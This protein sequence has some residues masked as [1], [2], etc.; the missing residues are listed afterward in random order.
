[1][2]LFSLLVVQVS[3]TALGQDPERSGQPRTLDPTALSFPPHPDPGQRP[4]VSIPTP[5]SRI[6]SAKTQIHT[7]LRAGF[8]Y[9]QS[10]HPH[11]KH[12]RRRD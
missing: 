12:H 8:P 6:M 10:Q 7:Y 4:P 2:L 11:D 9:Y 3:L 1:M 5:V